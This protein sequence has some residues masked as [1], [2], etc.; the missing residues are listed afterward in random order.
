MCNNNGIYYD[1]CPLNGAA[2][3]AHKIGQPAS[4]HNSPRGR[5]DRQC[6]N[7]MHLIASANTHAQETHYR[8]T[9]ISI[10]RD[11]VHRPEIN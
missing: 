5:A 7:V 9:L 10:T 2:F 6:A 11:N 1:D 3:V 8:T 4:G